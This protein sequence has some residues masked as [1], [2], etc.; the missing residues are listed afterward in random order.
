M[1][2]RCNTCI[3]WPDNRMH[4]APGKVDEMVAK[5]TANEGTIVCHSTLDLDRQAACR[6]FVDRH[7]TLPIRLGY[8]RHRRSRTRRPDGGTNRGCR[9]ASFIPGSGWNDEL[10]RS[11]RAAP[12][13]D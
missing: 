12:A 11:W 7:A 2:R 9:A 3:F 13:N 5:A 1:A 8:A 4:L 10:P 6:G